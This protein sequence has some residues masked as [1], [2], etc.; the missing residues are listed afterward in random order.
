MQVATQSLAVLL[1]FRGR[2]SGLNPVLLPVH[3]GMEKVHGIVYTLH[4]GR[5]HPEIPRLFGTAAE[6][7]GVE[8][9]AEAPGDG[10]V[11]GVQAG[12]E[13]HALVGHQ[14]DA[15]PD[16]LLRQL[17]IGDAV[18]EDAPGAGV[19]FDDGHAVAAVVQLV[20]RGK[21]RRAG[22]HDHD[23]LAR[24]VAREARLHQAVCKGV[25]DDAALVVMH[26]DRLVMQ[27]AG[28]GLLA[29]GGA[30]A[31][32]EL[33]EVVG[34]QQAGQGVAVV[35]VHEHVVPLGDQVVQ[36]AAELLSLKEDARLAEGHAAVHA[37]RA[38]FQPLRTLDGDIDV[39]P[40][41]GALKG[42]AA[43]VLT[44]RIFH[45]PCRFSHFQ[46]PPFNA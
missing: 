45:K 24:D 41:G 40:V 30:D 4:P 14:V 39:L 34:L 44:A 13:G 35:A 18:G 33:G 21:P 37:P 7:D 1:P 3:G 32:G 20:R 25:F 27:A 5:V 2:D 43:P 38:L 8:L 6:D 15:A 31:A 12:H 46:G 9:A 36:R 16:K 17:H 28:A 22:A 23:V 10:G 42:R 29:E 11:R 19:L 26:G